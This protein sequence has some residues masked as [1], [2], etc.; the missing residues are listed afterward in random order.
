VTAKVEASARQLQEAFQ[1]FNRMSLQLAAS[2][3]DLEQRVATLSEELAAAR[4]ERLRQLAEKERL[5]GRLAHLLDALPGGVVVLD[6]VATVV[7]AN[8]V[9]RQLLGE[10]LLGEAWLSVSARVVVTEPSTGNSVSLA[11]GTQLSLSTRSLAPEPGR[12]VLLSDVTENRAL[13][14]QVARQRRLSAMGEMAASLAHQIRTPLAAALLY[15]SHLTRARVADRDRVRFAERVVLRLRHLEQMVNDMLVFARGGATEQE[16]FLAASLAAD[17]VA[18]LEPQLGASAGRLVVHDEAPGAALRGNR[19]ALLGALLNLGTNALQAC[20][21]APALVLH[22]RQFQPGRLAVSLSD[23]GPGVP[24][25][26]RERIFE[27][28]FSTRAQGIGLGLAVVR[29]VV[30]GHGGELELSAAPGGGASFTLHLP[31]AANG[32][33]LPSGVHA[34]ALAARTGCPLAPAASMETDP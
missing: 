4:S 16:D 20:Q 27:P 15:M 21:L 3:R 17:L 25:E 12:I 7:E 14:E 22:L 9:A 34:P 1:V 23:N 8:P 28:F 30:R 29:A 24:A 11:N 10:P 6:G 2:Y 5:A 26:L 19:P 13:Q 33:A 18:A 31:L 32:D